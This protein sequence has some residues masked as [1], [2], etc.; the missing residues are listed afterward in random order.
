MPVSSSLAYHILSFNEW[1]SSLV[2]EKEGIWDIWVFV[3]MDREAKRVKELVQDNKRTTP[4][5]KKFK[6]LIFFSRGCE[7]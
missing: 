4:P 5:F 1:E 7:C 3:T 6:L 2:K